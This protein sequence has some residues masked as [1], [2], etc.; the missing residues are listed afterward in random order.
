MKTCPD[1][2]NPAT[3][4]DDEEQSVR[5]DLGIG[6]DFV[7][8]CNECEVKLLIGDGWGRSC[9]KEFLPHYLTLF[10][11]ITEE[12]KPKLQDLLDFCTDYEAR[13]STIKLME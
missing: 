10:D 6:D 13:R 9:F 8:T 11:K 4:T 7:M 12:R 1:C 3:W 2:G 5:D